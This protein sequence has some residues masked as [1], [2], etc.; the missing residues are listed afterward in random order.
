MIV[1]CLIVSMEGRSQQAARHKGGHVHCT[2]HF[3]LL[4]IRHDM[5]RLLRTRRLLAGW[6]FFFQQVLLFRR[7][8]LK[9][10]IAVIRR[11]DK[12]IDLLTQ[13]SA[14]LGVLPF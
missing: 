12:F 14:C 1:L 8:Q 2:A 11:A 13:L 10:R 6:V 9:Y 4:L 7:K 5:I 3:I